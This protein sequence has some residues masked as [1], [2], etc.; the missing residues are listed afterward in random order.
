MKHVTVSQSPRMQC[1]AGESCRAGADV[2]CA[3]THARSS[4]ICF[5]RRSRTLQA[6]SAQFMFEVALV[7]L[8]LREG[9]RSAAAV[10]FELLVNA[11]VCLSA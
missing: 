2:P 10:C 1:G 6:S 11:A 8:V 5:L 3:S 9:L 7:S 4:L